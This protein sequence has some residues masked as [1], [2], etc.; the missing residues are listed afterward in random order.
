MTSLKDK[1]K[2][3]NIYRFI[4]IIIFS[5]LLLLTFLFCVKYLATN[6]WSNDIYWLMLC[7][8][9]LFISYPLIKTYSRYFINNMLNDNNDWWIKENEKPKILYTLFTYAVI[10]ASLL[11][12]IYSPSL[13]VAYLVLI[14]G[15]VIYIILLIVLPLKQQQLGGTTEDREN[16]DLLYEREKERIERF[17]N[18]S[19]ENRIIK[20]SNPKTLWKIKHNQPLNNDEFIEFIYKQNNQAKEVTKRDLIRYILILKNQIS[21][22]DYKVNDNVEISSTIIKRV[23]I[24]NALLDRIGSDEIT[25]ARNAVEE[26][27]LYRILK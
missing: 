20:A 22:D 13:I 5:L 24:N 18:V 14:F 12:K 19:I 17:F 16:V 15:I 27:H 10:V 4:E 21:S 26:S 23:E 9:L 11:Y 25:K 6:D 7:F 3:L 1:I 2:S 8:S